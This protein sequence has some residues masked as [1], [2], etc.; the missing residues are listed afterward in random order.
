MCINADMYAFKCLRL[1]GRNERLKYTKFGLFR[2]TIRITRKSLK[3]KP[4]FQFYTLPAPAE[5]LFCAKL[6]CQYALQLSIKHVG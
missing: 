1:R 6:S 4:R 3:S 5:F 2:K